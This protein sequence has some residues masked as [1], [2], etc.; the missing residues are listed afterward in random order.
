MKNNYLLIVL[1]SLFMLHGSL[2][3]SQG[4]I[5]Q[6]KAQLDIIAVDNPGLS[7]L[8]ELSINGSSLDEFIRG[9]ANTNDLN[10]S[11]DKGL[12]V[13]VV[14]NFSNVTVADVLTFLVKK[15][16]LDIEFTGNIMSIGKYNP[17]AQEI[18]EVKEKA[19]IVQYFKSTDFL[20]LDLNNDDLSKVVRKITEVSGKN[21]VLA[22]QISSKKVSVYIKGVPFKNAIEKFAFANDLELVE[23]EDNFYL[24]SEKGKA[25]NSEDLKK[26]NQNK[27]KIRNERYERKKE[28]GLFLKVNGPNDIEI[29]AEDISIDEI[30]KALGAELKLN[31]YLMANL[32]GNKSLNL[33]SSTFDDLLSNLFE[34]TIYTY[35]KSNGVYLIGER[36]AEGLRNTIIFQLQNRSIEDLITFIPSDLTK[37]VE[38]KEFPD[39]NSLVISGSVP[40]IQDL[41]HFLEKID[42]VVPMIAI[43]VIIVDYRKNRSVST[44]ITAGLGNEPSAATNGQILPD[45]SFNFSSSSLNNVIG[46]INKGSTINLGKVTPNFYLSIKALET[47]G[48]LKVR[49]TPKLATLN[50]HEANLKIGNTEY[51]VNEQSI[52]QG[53]LS[54]QTQNNR[55][56]VAVNADLSIKIKPFVSGNDQITMEI[57]VEQ[58]DFTERITEDAPPGKVTRSFTSILRVKD[59]EIVLLGGLEEKSTNDSG[60]GLPLIARIPVLKWIFGNRTRSKSSSQLNIFIKPTVIY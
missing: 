44:G 43:E 15:Y 20:L 18:E 5:D 25:E 47:D 1:L 56:Y 59:N 50:G 52:F 9:I 26:A 23:T 24:L 6:I 7:N 29:S 39:L 11:V 13:L 55:T 54:P 32:Q 17:P 31:Y 21:V 36:K 48:I 33:Q 45:A 51:Y 58:S 12:D 53:S 3:F 14:N 16:Q 27:S 57:S 41:V 2:G 46:S 37:E 28:E 40:Q 38:L 49:S 22:P 42:Q 35:S 8:V 60:S 4:R 34:S 30:V 19:I 10:V